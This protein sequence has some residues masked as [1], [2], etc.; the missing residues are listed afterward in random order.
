MRAPTL[1]RTTMVP[2]LTGVQDLGVLSGDLSSVARGIN[3]AGH[4]V[5]DSFSDPNTS[6]SPSPFRYTS[7]AG[8]VSLNELLDPVTGEGWSLDHAYDINNLGQISGIGISGGKPHAFLLTPIPEPETY[9]LMLLG[10]SSLAIVSRRR[11]SG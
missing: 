10:L 9:A 6:G 3:N 5:G 7:A 4:V 11:R 8:L 1:K 2:S